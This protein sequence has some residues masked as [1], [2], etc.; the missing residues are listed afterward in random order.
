MK[1]NIGN[2]KVGDKEPCFVVAE[3]GSNHNQSF[4]LAIEMIDAAT[5]ARVDAVKFQTFKASEHYSKKAP[6]FNY[7]KNKNTYDLIKSLELNREWQAN[8]KIH[9]EKK[10]VLFFSSPCDS[11]AIDS[12]KK[13]DV[14]A[15]KVASFDLTDDRLI[16]EMAS[17]GKPLIMSTGMASLMEIQMAVDKAREVNNNKL[18]LLQCTSLYPAPS[19]LSNLNAMSM[20]KRVFNTLVGYSDHTIGEHIAL[21][22]IPL[23]AC[24]IEKHFT[25]DRNLPGPDHSFA[26]EPNEFKMMISNIR[27]IENALGDGIKNGPREEELEMAEKGKRS[28]HAKQNIKKGDSITNE[29]LAIKRPGLG[30]SHSFRK[31]IIGRKAICD[32]EKDQWITWNMI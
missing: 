7:L 19:N 15:Y 5:E 2:K 4:D 32:I 10:G 25:I 12:L 31:I 23:G 14:P 16:K 6:G 18:I 17:I 1:L 27:E 28:L 22:S 24:F 9:A 8:L 20:M 21:A 11:H 3:I 29:M 26:M 30:L 13:I